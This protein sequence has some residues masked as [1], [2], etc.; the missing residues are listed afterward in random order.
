M[1]APVVNMYFVAIVLPQDVNKKVL[2]HKTFMQEKYNCQVALKSP[3]HITIAPPFWMNAAKENDLVQAVDTLSRGFL[4]FPVTTNNFSAFIPKTI[5]IDILSNE[6][7]RFVKESAD[8]FFIRH[9][10]FNIKIEGR[11]FRPH[12]TIATRDL[13]KKSFQ[14]A[15]SFF[16]LQVF[17]E[18]WIARGL[19]V[20]RHNKKNWDV[21]HTSQFQ[22]I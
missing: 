20:L 18:E 11:P 4:A 5:F 8:D 12:I 13:H 6:Q 1:D 14:E 15:W 7:L 17:E 3:A 9:P 10:E 2:R 22:K 19:S 16:Q 21:I